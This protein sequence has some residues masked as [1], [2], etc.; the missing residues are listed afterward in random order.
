MAVFSFLECPECALWE[1]D[2]AT[3]LDKTGFPC[4]PEPLKTRLRWSLGHS[5]RDSLQKTPIPIQRC[6]VMI[7]PR[8]DGVQS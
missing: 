4:C 6:S 8:L 2:Q 1:R 3:Q 7:K 5:K